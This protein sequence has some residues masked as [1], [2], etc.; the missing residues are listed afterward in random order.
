[1]VKM[2]CRKYVW[3]VLIHLAGEH[4]G[5]QIPCLF[6]ADNRQLEISTLRFR[7]IAAVQS[8]YCIVCQ[9]NAAEMYHSV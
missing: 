4:L 3:E 2:L 7:D 5:G 6:S 1:M 8:M 9:I